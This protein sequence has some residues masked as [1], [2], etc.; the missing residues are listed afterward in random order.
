M[1]LSRRCVSNMLGGAIQLD[2]VKVKVIV[3]GKYILKPYANCSCHM[4]GVKYEYVF[5]STC[6]RLASC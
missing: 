1:L 5:E 6:L 3:A 2:K 4:S